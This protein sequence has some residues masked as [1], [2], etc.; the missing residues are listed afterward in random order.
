VLVGLQEGNTGLNIDVAVYLF[1]D[2]YRVG[3]LL[4][5]QV[6]GLIARCKDRLKL[7]LV[8]SPRELLM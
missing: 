1:E 3:L 5:E 8:T 6:S 7:D 2:S 4:L